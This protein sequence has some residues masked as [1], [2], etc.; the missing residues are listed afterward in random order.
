MQAEINDAFLKVVC[1]EI[2]WR[3]TTKSCHVM[4]CKKKI[5][6]VQ[7]Y[8]WKVSDQFIFCET[9]LLFWFYATKLFSSI[10]F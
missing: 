3:R 7:N 1:I 6:K 8:T 2:Y 4:D 9:L 5:T 10:M